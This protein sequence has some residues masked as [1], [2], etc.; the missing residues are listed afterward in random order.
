MKTNNTHISVVYS[1]SLRCLRLSSYPFANL[2]SQWD[3]KSRGWTL[4]PNQVPH[5][6][7]LWT[8]PFTLQRFMKLT[9]HANTV[10]MYCK[11][12]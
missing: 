2:E 12:N 10:N 4:F 9:Q 8:T 6:Q 1:T 11:H 5:A 7:P 3:R